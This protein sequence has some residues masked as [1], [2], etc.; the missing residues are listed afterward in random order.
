MVALCVGDKGRLADPGHNWNATD[1]ITNPTLPWKRLVWAAVGNYCYVVHY[2][3]GG[4]DHSFHILVA[5][6]ANNDAK[7]KI[8]W[9]AVGS[10][11][12]DYTAFLEALR[13]GKWG[14]RLNYSR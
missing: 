14:D 2:E 1:A 8:I 7:R 3:P 9:S 13:N 12:K 5:K 10:P 6:L 11:L 4:L